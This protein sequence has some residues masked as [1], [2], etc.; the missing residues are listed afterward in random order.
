MRARKRTPVAY[1]Y[2]IDEQTLFRENVAEM[3]FDGWNGSKWYEVLGTEDAT[4][5][6]NGSHIT[7]AEAATFSARAVR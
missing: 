3:T 6:C 1:Q 2:W 7:R 5:R 4:I